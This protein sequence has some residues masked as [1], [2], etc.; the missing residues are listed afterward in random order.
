VSFQSDFTIAELAARRQ[1]LAADLEPGA[2]ALIPGAGAPE[3]SFVF[4]Q[5]NSFYY[6]CGV[7]VPHAYLLLRAD[8]TAIL[9]LADNHYTPFVASNGD[10][11]RKTTGL[12]SIQSL[13]ALS[14]QLQRETVVYLP[15]V[16]G[17]GKRCSWDTLQFCRQ[18][19]MNDPFDGRRGRNSQVANNIRQQFPLL[20]IRNLTP[21][22]HEM[23]LIKSESEM[24]MMRRAGELTGLGALAAMRATKPGIMEYELHAELEHVYVKGGAWGDGYSP[25]IPGQGNAGDPHYFAND[26]VLEDGDI[27]LLDCAPDYRFYTSDIGRM[28]PVN[29]T[30]SV[31]QR[32]LY[33][34]VLRY[35]KTIL[36]MIKPGAMRRDI[37]NQAIEIMTPVFENWQFTS[38]AQRETAAILFDYDGHI[39]HGVGMAVHEIS[40]HYDRPLEPGMVFA[41]DPMAWDDKNETYYRVEDTV[42]VTA[43]GYENLTAAAP[44]E[45]EDIE[46]VMAGGTFQ[47][48]QLAEAVM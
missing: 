14:R 18:S 32:A 37:H 42:A 33:E 38:P 31:E 3:G 11:V 7:E 8:G 43:D 27:V 30:F 45:V 22:I 17:E 5:F 24:V 21:L 46:A 2:V 34:Y 39:S 36:S 6:F 35:H 15:S 25:I 19:A 12:E 47:P 26:G 10:W 40:L 29:G 9:Y 20:D 16:E 23:R 1:R 4:R 13:S 48:G 41:V 44:I 28:W